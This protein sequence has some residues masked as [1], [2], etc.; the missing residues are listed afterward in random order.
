MQFLLTSCSVHCFPFS[1]RFLVPFLLQ[2]SS[3]VFFEAETPSRTAVPAPLRIF[4]SFLCLLLSLGSVFVSL[5]WT[6]LDFGA[7]QDQTLFEVL[8]LLGM[9]LIRCLPC[10]LISFFF[11]SLHEYFIMRWKMFG[12]LSIVFWRLYSLLSSSV[13]VCV[14]LKIRSFGVLLPI[15]P[16]VVYWTGGCC[17]CLDLLLFYC[18]YC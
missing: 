5:C 3:V 14:P 17:L 6:L 1:S 12:L 10:I 9:E 11:N 7:S 16:A 2:P 18:A 8:L 4:S 15:C 13:S